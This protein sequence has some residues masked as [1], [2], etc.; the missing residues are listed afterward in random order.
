[1]INRMEKKSELPAQLGV[2]HVDQ[3]PTE[4]WEEWTADTLKTST[5][6]CRR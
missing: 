2:M 5:R 1:M 6:C 3:M 4:P